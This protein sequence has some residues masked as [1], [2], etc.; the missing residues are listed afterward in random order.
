MQR[1]LTGVF[2]GW[3]RKQIV[4]ALVTGVGACAER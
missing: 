3:I 1:D 2:K 4:L